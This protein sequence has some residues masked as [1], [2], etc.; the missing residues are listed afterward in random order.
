MARV[1]AK[2]RYFSEGG[3]VPFGIARRTHEKEDQAERFI[4]VGHAEAV[5]ESGQHARRAADLSV[6]K[7]RNG[8]AVAEPCGHQ[9]AGFQDMLQRLFL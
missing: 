4:L 1:G 9:A 7:V 5:P 3:E 6:V 8:D 2:A